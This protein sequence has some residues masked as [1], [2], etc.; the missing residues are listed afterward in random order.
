M[1][2]AAWRGRVSALSERDCYFVAVGTLGG[3]RVGS[4]WSE[5]SGDHRELIGMSV[6]G[7]RSFQA[8]GTEIAVGF[9]SLNKT[10]RL[11][12]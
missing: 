4:V 1:E 7:I 11:H 8:D 5:P 6:A 2:D 3:G 10:A 9:E 12:G